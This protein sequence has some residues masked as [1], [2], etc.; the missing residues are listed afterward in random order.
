MT[1]PAVLARVAS[2]S[3]DKV[4]GPK[5]PSFGGAGKEFD[6][7]PIVHSDA[8]PQILLGLRSPFRFSLKDAWFLIP[9]ASWNQR[10]GTGKRAS[11]QVRCQATI[12]GG[13]AVLDSGYCR[14]SKPIAS[15]VIL[16]LH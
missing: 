12:F 4:V 13:L 7:R 15:A 10:H 1:E 5:V 11:C 8:N 6:F 14:W 9:P 2:A 16:S 3:C